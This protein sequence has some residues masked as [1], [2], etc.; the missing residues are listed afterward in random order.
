LHAFWQQ[1][2]P[3]IA[4]Q[5]PLVTHLA[6]EFNGKVQSMELNLAIGKTVKS[7]KLPVT[8]CQRFASKINHNYSSLP[9]NMVEAYRFEIHFG[10]NAN[11]NAISSIL[12]TE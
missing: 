4:L 2:F 7:I 12:C 6:I 11:A 3:R 9:R 8:Q 10:A 1:Y 5:K